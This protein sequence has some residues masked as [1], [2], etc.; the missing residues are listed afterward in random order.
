ME[1]PCPRLT[2][3]GWAATVKD[4]PPVT[5]SASLT[6]LDR[7]PEVPVTVMLAVPG[8]AELLTVSVNRLLVTAL[9]GPKDA[10]TPVG[11]PEML[12][13]TV[14][15]KPF[16]GLTVIVVLPVLPAAIERLDVDAVRPNPGE[17]DAPVRSLMRLWPAGLPHPVARS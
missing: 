7:L 15:V 2:L 9:A 12:N 5:V 14:P 17:F 16:C 4:G 6:V 11:R 10:V 3:A 13:A 8:D 1:P